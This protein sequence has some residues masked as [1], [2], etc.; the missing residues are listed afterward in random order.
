MSTGVGALQLPEQ[1]SVKLGNCLVLTLIGHMN[2]IEEV[3]EV[4]LARGRDLLELLLRGIAGGISRS[5]LHVVTDIISTMLGSCITELSHWME[6]RKS[7]VAS[8]SL[9]VI[10]CHQ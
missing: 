6:V 7:C 10:M 1:P 2:N 3:K 4:I 9:C 8:D 5:Q